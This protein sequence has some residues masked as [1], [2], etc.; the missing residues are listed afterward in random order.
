MHD[1]MYMYLDLSIRAL[2]TVVPAVAECSTPDP[3][4]NVPKMFASRDSHA[5][6]PVPS[7]SVGAA[8]ALYHRN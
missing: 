7:P 6:Y 2:P 5:R 3:G 8:N 4:G 1:S